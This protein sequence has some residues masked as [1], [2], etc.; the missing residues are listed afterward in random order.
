[1]IA[2]DNKERTVGIFYYF[3]VSNSATVCR[4]QIRCRLDTAVTHLFLFQCREYKISSSFSRYTS[5]FWRQ[6]QF[7][8]EYICTLVNLGFATKECLKWRLFLQNMW[9]G[10]ETKINSTLILQLTQ[11]H[12]WNISANYL[13]PDWLKAEQVDAYIFDWD[14]SAI[15]DIMYVMN[16]KYAVCVRIYWYPDRAVTWF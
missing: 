13:W 10:L 4:I 7:R 12:F 15:S 11:S 5:I 3:L 2:A 16:R 6:L 14:I 1:M 9:G 8:T